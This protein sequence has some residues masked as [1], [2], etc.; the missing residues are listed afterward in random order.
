MHP[1]PQADWFGK[2]VLPYQRNLKPPGTEHYN[3]TNNQNI[4]TKSV[5]S[6]EKNGGSNL[7][8]LATGSEGMKK[9]KKGRRGYL[10]RSGDGVKGAGR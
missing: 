6:P 4:E 10:S 1:H 8:E 3:A 7:Y 2:N 9:V 5:Q